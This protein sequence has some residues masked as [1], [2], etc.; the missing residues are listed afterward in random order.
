MTYDELLFEE[1]KESILKR[2]KNMF[3]KFIDKETFKNF[4]EKYKNKG[5]KET[6]SEYIDNI[7]KF[8]A[9]KTNDVAESER[10]KKTLE[11]MK[12][13]IINRVII[14]AKIGGLRKVLALI[15]GVQTVFIYISTVEKITINPIQWFKQLYI[16]V[17]SSLSEVH[18]MIMSSRL[19]KYL[20]KL[21]RIGALLLKIIAAFAILIW[22]AFVITY[23]PLARIKIPGLNRSLL[24]LYGELIFKIKMRQLKQKANK[25]KETLSTILPI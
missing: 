14:P 10:V 3:S 1:E 23:T 17:K 24:E 13:Y 12:L 4:K 8:I 15:A 16:V 18:Q 25:Y 7:G 9:K 5:L 2:A 6:A 21:G 20:G 19:G 22:V 11:K